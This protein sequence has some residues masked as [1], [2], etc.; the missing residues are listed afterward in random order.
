MEK[1]EY[2]S[3]THNTNLIDHDAAVGTST[4]NSTS[5]TSHRCSSIF[6]SVSRNVRRTTTVVQEHA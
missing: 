3:T 6:E 4:N 2:N 1:E 5:S